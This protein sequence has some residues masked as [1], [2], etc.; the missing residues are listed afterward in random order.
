MAAQ[1]GAE[2]L[3]I[4]VG[5]ILDRG[6][7][8]VLLA[9]RPAHA[10]HGGLWEFPGGKRESGESML[11]ALRRELRE[12]LGMDV[13]GARPLLRIPHDY[14]DVCVELH[15]WMVEEW[16]GE[17]RG[18]EG[19]A[20]E[21]VALEDLPRRAFPEANRGIVT[22]LL[23]PEL[24][25]ITP[26]REQYDEAFFTSTAALVDAGVRMLLFRAPRLDA[27]ARATALERLA[28]ICRAA[29]AILVV[30][31]TIAEARACGADGVHLTARRLTAERKRP[32]ARPLLVGASCHDAGELE[33][34]QAI[35]ADYALLG[36]VARTP[37]H[38]RAVPLGWAGL[39][40]LLAPG[41][42]MPIYALGGLTPA[43]LPA[44]RRAGARG[45]ALI[46]SIW[47]AA[48]PALVVR[49]A[50]ARDQ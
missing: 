27:G 8:R 19:Q 31:G 39:A 29:G 26:D 20:H 9:R 30:N 32:C 24:V 1:G 42:R 22:A 36:P 14:A 47:S 12:E 17:P 49:A 11:E 18:L 7:A 15:V 21:W 48:D 34:A 44:A 38:A 4:A 2:R 25:V 13:R 37:T 43:D 40:G 50:L 16:H 6:A 33:R 45:V 46:S 35:D 41:W 23:L 28:A 10:A 5:V 3:Q